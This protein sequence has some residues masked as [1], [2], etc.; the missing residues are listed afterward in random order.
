[1]YLS[2]GLWPSV[3]SAAMVAT[4]SAKIEE[5]HLDGATLYWIES[6]PQE[7]GRAVIMRRCPDGQREELTPVTVCVAS[8][9]HSYGGAAMVVSEG[10]VYFSNVRDGRIYRLVPGQPP[11]PL[12]A[13]GQVR[14]ADL[15]ID[16]ARNRLIGVRED[17][18]RPGQEA[19]NQLV[20]ISL[21][22]GRVTVF[23]SGADFYAAPRLSPDGR[24]LAWIQWHHPQMP[25]DATQ[26]CVARLATDGRMRRYGV[27]IDGESMPRESV[28]SPTWSPDGQLYYASDRSGW[29]NL[30]RFN[31]QE[32]CDQAVTVA[33]GDVGAPLWRLGQSYFAFGFG[34][35]LYYA[36]LG[37]GRND[38]RVAA[39]TWDHRLRT[40][41]PEAVEIQEVR[42]SDSCLAVL[43]SGPALPPTIFLLDADFQE[44]DRIGAKLPVE[45]MFI[46]QPQDI[47]FPTT[48]DDEA[49]GYFYPPCYPGVTGPIADRPPLIVVAH[50][51]PTSSA[52]RRFR[53]EIQFWTSHG[54]AVLDVD[55]RGSSG[56]GR[57]YRKRLAGQW[58]VYDVADCVAGVRYLSGLDVIDPER[59]AIR[60]GSAGGFTVLSALVF[61][62]A[63]KAGVS[64]YGISDLSTLSDDTH[65]FE[66]RYLDGLVPAELRAQ[67]SPINAIGE[68]NCPMIIFQGLKDQAVPPVQAEKMVEV[69]RAKGLEYEYVTFVEEGHGFRQAANIASSLERELAFF[70]RVFRLE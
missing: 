31:V 64:Y 34:K 44:V 49:H 6:R 63:F 67:R 27:V 16:Q 56:Y 11:E 28:I 20:N 37:Q 46:S 36:V 59:V 12:T 60:G 19:E 47:S 4:A 29:W 35:R 8:Q 65:K 54:F 14:Y 43:A 41:P 50:G 38:L 58:G 55:Y 45:K 7:Q 3:F 61:H 2:Y 57:Q 17:H 15:V 40:L 23:E 51:G 66:S 18:R 9:V 68:L 21:R 24:H 26:L 42:A 13:K 32:R 62:H 5:V 25:W 10:V 48:M 22:T 33:D 52:S 1:M 30:Y 70:R 69:L 53:P 39:T